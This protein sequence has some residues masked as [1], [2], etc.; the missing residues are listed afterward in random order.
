[1]IADPVTLSFQELA[2]VLHLSTMWSFDRIREYAIDEIEKE[3]RDPFELLELS[4]KCNVEKWRL[5]SYRRMCE[6]VQP[7]TLAEASRLGLPRFVAICHVRERWMASRIQNW[8]C[9]MC[10]TCI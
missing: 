1:M 2:D 5:L 3:P 9:G 4:F 10:P 7:L 8:R 6:R